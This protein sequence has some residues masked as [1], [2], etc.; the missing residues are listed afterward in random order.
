M[1]KY[2]I[3][4]D[5]GHYGKYNKSTVVSSYYESDMVWKLHNLLATYLKEYGF[6]VKKTRST[7]AKD[8]DLYSRG[9][10]AK[11]CNLFLS[12]HSNACASEKVD[13]VAVYHL[14]N[15][16][17]SKADDVS[18]AVAKKL[19][20]VIADVMDV[21]QG[22]KVLTRSVNWDRNKDGYL[23]D[24]YYGVLNGAHCV[25]V[26]GLIVEHSFHT[27]TRATK[28]LLQDSNLDKLAKAEAKAIAEYYG[29]TKLAT[30]KE[31]EKAATTTKKQL[32]RIRKTW[33]DAA[34]QIGAY[35]SLYNAKKACKDGYSVFDEAGNTVYTKTAASKFA[36]YK[37]KVTCD[38]LNVR[39]NADLQAP[40]V[41][42]VNK[43]EVYTIVG[44]KEADG[45]KWGKLKSGAGY[46]SLHYTEKI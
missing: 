20:P 9:A 8:L 38:V 6:A 2:T 25:D 33:S 32:Y 10:A 19:A 42:T 40:V 7:Q 34:S 31:Q 18:K 5:A 3:C 21:K 27:N 28:W 44:E 17:T 30:T 29:M 12:L 14:V 22:Y 37:V 13:Y 26:P 45:I 1:A 11:G 39:K 23:N 36:N 16:T 41:T 4:L 35:T 24:N 15:D 43:N 46:I